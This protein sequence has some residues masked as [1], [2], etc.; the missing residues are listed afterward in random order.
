MGDWNSGGEG[1]H[2]SLTP[3]G[4]LAALEQFSFPGSRTNLMRITDK[5]S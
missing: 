3:R 4:L 2:P 1:G 5:D